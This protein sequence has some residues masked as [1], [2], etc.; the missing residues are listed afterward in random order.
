MAAKVLTTPR[1][2]GASLVAAAAFGV[3]LAGKL[4]GWGLGS[5]SGNGSGNGSISD[6]RIDGTPDGQ[7]QMPVPPANQK[8]VPAEAVELTEPKALELVVDGAGYALKSDSSENRTPITLDQIPPLLTRRTGDDEGV[9]VRIFRRENALPSA[10]E[11]L[12]TALR[13]AGVPDSAVHKVD[14]LIK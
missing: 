11:K 4:P 10:E 7:T 13:A 12:D 1:L 9:R 3:Y 6:T 5:G 8:T 14:G 2:F